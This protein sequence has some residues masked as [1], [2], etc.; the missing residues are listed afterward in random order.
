MAPS[1][2]SLITYSFKGVPSFGIKIVKLIAT[3]EKKLAPQNFFTSSVCGIIIPGYKPTP[4]K[5]RTIKPK[6]VVMK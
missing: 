1:L 5:I 4:I 6:M 2:L 3:K